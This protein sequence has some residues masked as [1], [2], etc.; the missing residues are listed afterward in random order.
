MQNEEYVLENMNLVKFIASKYFTKNIGIEYED[1]VSYGTIGLI[2]AANSYR[3]DKNCKFSTIAS[4]KIRA[5]IVDEIRRH[6]P[7][8][9]NDVAKINE[10]NSAVENLQ[11]KLLREPTGEEIS[12]Y[13]KVSKSEISKIESRINIM[14]TTSLDTV[15][16]E[17]NT[18]VSIIDTIKEDESLLPENIIEEDEK[19]NILTRAI[20]MLKEKDK[21][22]LSL[23]YYEELT[24]KEIGRVLEVSESRVCQLHS[25]AI[26]N[27]RNAM[28]RLNY[29]IA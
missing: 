21:L 12:K 17:G 8:S 28:K 2:D 27:L 25:R 18:D 6:S 15:I 29:N 26:V 5:A 1:L 20:D 9:R 3:D 16:F 14:S 4:L 7:I 19:L 23:Y 10:Y 11:N 24:L 22:V 13:L